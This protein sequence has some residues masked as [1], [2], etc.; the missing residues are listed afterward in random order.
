MASAVSAPIALAITDISPLPGCRVEQITPETTDFLSIAARGT[1]PGN[2]RQD[3]R[4]PD[5][6][7]ASRATHAAA[8]PWASSPPGLYGVECVRDEPAFGGGGAEHLGRPAEQQDRGAIRLALQ[9]RSVDSACLGRDT[10]PAGGAG[11]CYN[12]VSGAACLRAPL[13][14][15]ENGT[16]GVVGSAQKTSLWRHS[17]R[18]VSEATWP[19]PRLGRVTRK[20]T[21]LQ[22]ARGLASIR[23]RSQAFSALAG[24]APPSALLTATLHFW[25]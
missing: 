8:Q 11:A 25:G 10:A 19:G 9:L 24:P 12:M 16:G 3:C 7:R 13:R 5:C 18:T 15:G 2:R 23:E 4:C 20:R 1:G 21:W 22:A 14:H 6:G 17:F